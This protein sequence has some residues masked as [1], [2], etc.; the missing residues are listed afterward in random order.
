M[1]SC[2]DELT[3][4]PVAQR[5]RVDPERAQPHRSDRT[6]AIIPEAIG[7]LSAHEELTALEPR[8]RARRRPGR[9]G[10]VLRDRRGL[11]WACRRTTHAG[12]TKL[13]HRAA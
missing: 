4:P 9:R 5:N 3:E 13:A 1:A 6:L 11:A 7:I 12:G 8:H 10:R 2:V